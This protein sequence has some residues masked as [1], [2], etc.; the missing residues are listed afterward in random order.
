MLSAVP[1]PVEGLSYLPDFISIA[2]EA[3]LLSK[4]EEIGGVELD[5]AAGQRIYRDRGTCAGWKDLN[6]RRSM[7]FG[8]TILPR[9]STLVPVAMPPFMQASYPH[10]LDKIA[11]L[12][13]YDTCK[14]SRPNHVLLNEYLPGQ[15]IAA[16]EDGDAYHPVVCTLS[17]GSGT[18]LELYEY[19]GQATEEARTILPDPIMSIYAERRSLLV[20]SGA[21]YTACLHGI[22]ARQVD[23]AEQIQRC[24]NVRAGLTS[25]ALPASQDVDRRRR[26]SLTMRHVP[27]V[28]RLL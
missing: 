27:K 14:T 10:I 18:I 22:A 24:A 2:D 12:G 20:L 6:G 21:A 23:S 11:Q 19:E 5:S 4:I 13:L 28:K 15:G 9:T 8:G 1:G 3:H 16:H 7:Y 25:S 17:L 26:V